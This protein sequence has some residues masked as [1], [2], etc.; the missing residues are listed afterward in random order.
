MAAVLH[1]PTVVHRPSMDRTPSFDQSRSRS[2]TPFSDPAPHNRSGSGDS[3]A[4]PYNQS[5]PGCFP[6][7]Q[8][9][10]VQPQSWTTAAIPA[11]AFHTPPFHGY[12]GQPGFQQFQQS[13]ADFAA[14]ANAYQHMMMASVT[15]A[16]QTVPT[17]PA[18][19]EYERRGSMSEGYFDPSYAASQGQNKP[20]G[21]GQQQQ[22]FHHYKRGPSRVASREQVRSASMPSK[23]DPQPSSLPR[24]PSAPD[25]TDQRT[26]PVST[27]STLNPP[28][29]PTSELDPSV[30]SFVP[31]ARLN[32]EMRRNSHSSDRSDREN[33][34]SSR[35]S[36]A[37]SSK[38]PTVRAATPLYPGPITNATNARPSPLSNSTTP[39]TVEKGSKSGLKSKIFNKSEKNLKEQKKFVSPVKRSLP[40]QTFSSP[41]ETSTRSATP[42]VTPPHDLP[43]PSAPF[44]N[45]AAAGS[46]VSLAGTERTERTATIG[47][48][49]KSKGKRSLFRMKNMSTDN[50]SLSSTVSSASMMI[51]KMGSIGKLAKRNSLMG[52]SRIFKEKPKDEDAGLPQKE[53]KK[54]KKEKKKKSKSKGEA[55]PAAISH[56][57][58]EPE[59]LINDEEDRAL[60]GLTP[61][62]KLARQYTLR[63][64]AEA[65]QRQNDNVAAKSTPNQDVVGD[66]ESVTAAVPHEGP[67]LG[68]EVV[69]VQPRQTPTLVHAVAVTE[70]EYDSEDDSSDEGD[71]MEDLTMTMGRTRLSD[72]AD[73]EFKATWGNAYID[74]NAVPKKG[75][76]KQSSSY[77]SQD[78]ETNNRPRSNSTHEAISAKPGPLARLPPSDPARLDGLEQLLHPSDDS[79]NPSLPTSSPEQVSPAPERMYQLPVQNTSAPTLSFMTPSTHHAP[80]RSMT[81]PGRKRLLWAPECAV[82]TTYDCLTYDRRSEPATCNRLTPELAMAIKQEL[83][84]FKL[85]MPIHPESRIYTHYFA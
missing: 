51:R 84:A 44:A 41:S 18:S 49:T 63:S 52:I 65:A 35:S 47:D 58:A 61:A 55:A 78:E 13:Q 29:V 42:P 26:F 67:N 10:S 57:T 56:A 24:S 8:F 33:S 4:S 54:I 66:I 12:S 36:S 73:A 6:Q 27:P 77:S 40:P 5:Y 16:H 53:V 22:P 30:A 76:L 48:E 31:P 45:V 21:K 20:H 81:A 74:K 17:P 75:I 68:P 15:G 38:P 59:R 32:T 14:W 50:I 39:E 83:N 28:T 25:A 3:E 37:A 34:P 72:E 85:E 19:A 60:A 1:M 80:P 9:Y 11:S 43:A 79:K 69:H 70:H 2:G 62:A 7:Q 71:T 64:R 23:A 46:E 82:Y